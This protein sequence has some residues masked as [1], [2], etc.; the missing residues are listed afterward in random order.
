VRSTERVGLRVLDA[1]S[2]KDIV[3][4]A[5]LVGERVSEPLLLSVSVIVWVTLILDVAVGSLVSVKDADLSSVSDAVTVACGEEV[6][7]S[8]IVME[9]G[10]VTV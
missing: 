3:R 2:L 4:A 10:D 5:V 6:T 7:E 8:E 1:V 9:A